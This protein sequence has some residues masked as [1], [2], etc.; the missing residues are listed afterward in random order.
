MCEEPYLVG[1]PC[2]IKV[3]SARCS[4]IKM[5]NAGPEPITLIRGKKTGHVDNVKRQTLAPFKADQVNAEKQL[6]SARQKGEK[7]LTNEFEK[8]CNLEVPADYEEKYHALLTK[9]RNIFSV[10]KC[11]LRYCDTVLHK[12]FMET[13]E[14]FYVKQFKILEAHQSFL[15]D[16]VWE[17]LKAGI[18][19]PF[20]S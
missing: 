9:H 18:I 4:L 17:W 10:D 3:D 1:Q 19:Q 8:M 14:P 20:C 11:D 12:L 15:K 6:V 16:Q 7:K 13:E 2:L 5:F